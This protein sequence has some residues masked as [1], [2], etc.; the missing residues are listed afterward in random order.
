MSRSFGSLKSEKWLFYPE[1]RIREEVIVPGIDISENEEFRC[2]NDVD[3]WY[4]ILFYPLHFR[5]QA[6]KNP[7]PIRSSS[8]ILQKDRT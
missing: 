7:E 4:F 3:S 8:D 1:I 5:S 6:D 2:V